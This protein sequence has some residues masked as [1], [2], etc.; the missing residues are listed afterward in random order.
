ML[1]SII[2][3]HCLSLTHLTEFN[4]FTGSVSITV[5]QGH[6]WKSVKQA[7]EMKS[8]QSIKLDLN[9]P[10]C[11]YSQCNSV[12]QKLAQLPEAMHT[13]SQLTLFLRQLDVV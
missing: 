10:I 8:Y 6:K 9:E 13:A 7:T 11:L 5:Q 12:L 2:T 1:F 3:K 4:Y